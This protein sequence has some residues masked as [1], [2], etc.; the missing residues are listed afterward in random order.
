M[1]K[2]ETKPITFGALKS[3]AQ[4][5]KEL[6]SGR[7]AWWERVKSNPDLYVEIR[8]DNEVHVYY[9]GGRVLRMRYCSKRKEVQ[10]F[11]HNKYLTRDE[12]ATGYEN[13][14]KLLDAQLDTIIENVHLYS[15]KYGIEDKEK[16][17]EKYIQGNL[18]INHRSQYLDS[19][20]AYNSGD[21]RIDLVECV[22]GEIRFIELKRIDDA[23]MVTKDGKPEIVDQ[24]E[25][26]QIFIDL[27]EKEIIDYYQIV[28]DIKARL[29]LSIPPISPEKLNPMPFLLIFNRWVKD[30][31]MREKHK[32]EMEKILKDKKID[33]KIINSFED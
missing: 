14:A 3:D 24:I 18:I 26:Y 12:N 28:Y 2:A 17:S 16:W 10:A 7:Y 20:F 33:Y 9:E 30:H 22:N 29:G 23:R 32:I 25:Q 27:H 11:T 6:E 4:I 5:F 31:P 1:K 13:C 19:E 15:R 8:K 21:I